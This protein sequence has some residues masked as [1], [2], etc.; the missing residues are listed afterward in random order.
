MD[1]LDAL[2]AL[3]GADHGSAVFLA[4]R[5]ARWV[6]ELRLEAAALRSRGAS[7]RVR[8]LLKA[9]YHQQPAP[10]TR[11]DRRE[12]DEVQI[13]SSWLYRRRSQP[14]V[15]PVTADALAETARSAV[16]FARMPA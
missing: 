12:L 5:R 1:E 14:G 13:V 16:A 4:I 6:G 9:A 8:A 11:I 15:F 7:A 3:P 10:S 2:V